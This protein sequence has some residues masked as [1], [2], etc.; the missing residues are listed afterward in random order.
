MGI[1]WGSSQT[2]Y[3]L[4]GEEKLHLTYPTTS[5]SGIADNEWLSGQLN[6]LTR[7]QESKFLE[8][9]H[10]CEEEGY[11]VPRRDGKEADY[12]NAML[13]RFLRAKKF[14]VKN[15]LSQFRVAQTWQRDHAIK[16]FYSE[17]DVDCYED[18]RRMFAQWTGRRDHQG[19]PIYVFPLRHL[20]K[21]KMEAYISKMSSSTAPTEETPSIPTKIPG[22]LLAFHALYENLLDFVMPLCSQLPR[23]HMEIP[24]SASTHIIDVTGLTLR[25]FLEIKRYLQ[26]GSLLATT[27][28]PETL[29]RIFIIGA[30]PVLRT[31]WGFIKQWV[32]PETFSKIFILSPAEVP[33]TLLE[34]M[35][36]S[37]LPQQYGGTLK[38]EWGDMP[39]LDESARKLAPGLY[40]R[41]GDG[42]A[43][44]VKGPVIWSGDSIQVLGTIAG[45]K[46]EIIIPL[47]TT[48]ESTSV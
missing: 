1:W 15:A 3:Q 11:F 30:P 5:P 42:C 41:V 7:E 25:H 9:K 20:T 2:G 37:S 13:L 39:D 38:W 28:Y 26:G 43:E 44:Y 6:H 12:D 10:L 8:F 35:P 33:R 31:A 21:E 48:E 17:M 29:S 32:D 47:H 19:R 27:H 40:Q 22:H 45:K 18:S 24:V 16:T 46:R 4:A 23:P 34:Y 14:Q 36:A